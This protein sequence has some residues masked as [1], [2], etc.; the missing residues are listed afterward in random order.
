[1][2]S[3]IITLALISPLASAAQVYKCKGPDGGTIFTHQACSDS[4]AGEQVK[5]IPSSGGMTMGNSPAPAADDPEFG[6][7]QEI[8]TGLKTREASGIRIIGVGGSPA[9][10]CGGA[11]STE[12]RTAIIRNE[13]FPG[14]SAED[15][16][17]SW[18]K[19][20]K[21]NRSSH[22][23]DQWVYRTGSVS[24][25]YLYVEDGCVKSWN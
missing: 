25:Q 5:I 13:V 12:I 16:I 21:I 22:G 6:E 4:S 23:R 24:A 11:T 1:M 3:L 18:G 19:P 2:R 10:P 7:D 9:T 14:M 17:K 8:R 15:A 20:N